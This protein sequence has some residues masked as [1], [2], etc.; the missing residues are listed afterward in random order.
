[1]VELSKLCRKP[2]VC[3]L[4][5]STTDSRNESTN[6]SGGG[7]LSLNTPSSR[8]TRSAQAACCDR[9]V[10]VVAIIETAIQAFGRRQTARRIDD[11][12]ELATPVT[13]QIA[14]DDDVR[15]EDL[16]GER[17]GIRGTVGERGIRAHNPTD[18]RIARIVGVPIRVVRLLADH[19]SPGDPHLLKGL[20][21]GQQRCGDRS[22]VPGRYVV[23]QVE[24][25]R[26]CGRRD[27]CGWIL[28]AHVPA[29]DVAHETGWGLLVVVL[30]PRGDEI[31]KAVVRDA[32]PIAVVGHVDDAVVQADEQAAR[33]GHGVDDPCPC[34]RTS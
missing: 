21:P 22:P 27:A 15:P 24:N 18:N 34:P 1:M 4:S 8:S 13:H 28:L 17:I 19:D 6:H 16:T 23:G 20:I 12:L 3:P 30:A 10:A 11:V 31:T 14:V 33:V 25:D 32:G 26:I 7:A 2:S 5:C 9:F 29:L